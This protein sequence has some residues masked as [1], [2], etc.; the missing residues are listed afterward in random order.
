MINNLYA[1]ANIQDTADFFSVDFPQQ[2]N[3]TDDIDEEE[4]KEEAAENA[5]RDAELQEEIENFDDDSEAEGSEDGSDNES[6]VNINFDHESHESFPVRRNGQGIRP[7]QRVQENLREF[8]VTQNEDD[9]N[10]HGIRP[11]QHVQENLRECL[12]TKNDDDRNGHGIRPRQ[13]VQENLLDCL[14]TQNDDDNISLSNSYENRHDDNPLM[15]SSNSYENRHG[16]NPLMTTSNS[17]DGDPNLSSNKSY[18]NGHDD[19]PEVSLSSNYTPRHDIPCQNHFD[20]TDWQYLPSQN[21][22]GAKPTEDI[23]HNSG[24]ASRIIYNNV[25]HHLGIHPTPHTPSSVLIA[26]QN[27]SNDD[28]PY[29]KPVGDGHLLNGTKQDATL[30]NLHDEYMKL[31]T[32]HNNAC[33][34]LKRI[35]KREK[36]TVDEKLSEIRNLQINLELIQGEKTSLVSKLDELQKYTS[37]YE[38]QKKKQEGKIAALESELASVTDAKNEMQSELQSCEEKIESLERQLKGMHRSESLS[39]LRKQHESVLSELKLRHQNEVLDFKKF[40]DQLESELKSKSKDV[41]HL[42]DRVSELQKKYDHLVIEKSEIFNNLSSQLEATQKQ[43]QQLLESGGMIDVSILKAKVQ[44]LEKDKANLSEQNSILKEKIKSLEAELHTTEALQRIA[45]SRFA[46][47]NTEISKNEI[48][49]CNSQLEMALKNLRATRGENKNLLHDLEEKDVKIHDLQN[50]ATFYESR[51][52]DS[53]KKSKELEGK[54]LSLSTVNAEMK[55]SFENKVEKLEKLVKDLRTKFQKASEKLKQTSE[56]KESF[57]ETCEKLQKRVAEMIEHHANE[58][59]KA[60]EECRAKFMELHEKE[61]SE[62]KEKL[63]SDSD[64]D[65]ICLRAKYENEI[66]KLQKDLDDAN[67][68]LLEAKQDYIKIFEENKELRK[69]FNDSTRPKE[70]T[71][72]EAFMRAEYENKLEQMK[73]QLQKENEKTV[74][75]HL[76]I[77]IAKIKEEWT[78]HK[79]AEVKNFI[80]STKKQLDEKFR[81]CLLKERTALQQAHT[82][83]VQLLKNEYEKEKLA[84]N[85]KLNKVYQSEW[86]KRCDYIRKQQEEQIHLLEK[87]YE[88][89]IQ[90]M[91]S[92]IKELQEKL[93]SPKIYN[94]EVEELKE[95]FSQKESAWKSESQ[96]HLSMIAALKATLND[97]EDIEK[98]L[99]EKLNKYKRYCEKM[100]KE[101]KNETSL[102]NRK[103]SELQKKQEL[104]QMDKENCEQRLHRT[105]AEF[106]RKQ[107]FSKTCCIQTDQEVVPKQDLIEMRKLFFACLRSI[108]EDNKKCLNA[109]KDRSIERHR[110]LI[111]QYHRQ[112]TSKM[113]QDHSKEIHSFLQSI[114]IPQT[115]AKTTISSSP[116]FTFD[117]SK[118]AQNFCSTKIRS[119]PSTNNKYAHNKINADQEDS[120]RIFANADPA[121]LNFEDLSFDFQLRRL[122]Q[123]STFDSGKPLTDTGFSSKR[124]HS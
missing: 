8:L 17:Y 102:L 11:R 22:Y 3:L 52:N 66:S 56:M 89:K 37:D 119:S 110:Q 124:A 77:E 85:S 24:N 28:V 65:L 75:T 73:E 20:N 19:N 87:D 34:E 54:V 62:L 46:Q 106:S 32:F 64:T 86:E 96:Q 16:D 114:A 101:Y 47:D 10:G 84:L 48:Q 83:K 50:K 100:E 98:K 63:R 81:D 5:R 2:E 93:P 122:P 109:A 58:K 103:V 41:M 15:T 1:M 23:S 99:R 29:T 105:E 79:L 115:R 53:E 36:E 120:A 42:E 21:N 14:V 78:K 40:I 71:E 33:Q 80:E 111:L 27:K 35:K 61:V 44:D 7:R 88:K 25:N 12:V 4:D 82:E 91:E 72:I 55:T 60:V 51:F 117:V 123:S 67:M 116:T 26:S 57:A 121:Q 108:S 9:R 6:G 31:L 43:C 59:K 13:R 68:R 107:Q 45:T 104:L 90:D 118:H 94:D 38:L 18:T 76:K 113:F 74:G 92:K 30:Q 39:N 97:Q 69:T 112:L 95:L 49:N 70:R